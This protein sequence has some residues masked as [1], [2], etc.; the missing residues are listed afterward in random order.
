MNGSFTNNFEE[1]KSATYAASI[2]PIVHDCNQDDASQ[3]YSNLGLG[4]SQ[5]TVDVL[6]VKHA[7]EKNYGC[8]GITCADI[9]G[10][11]EGKYYGHYSQPCTFDQQQ[12]G[13][14]NTL[15]LV[16]VIVGFVLV[17]CFCCIVILCLRKRCRSRSSG[18]NGP[19][20]YEDSVEDTNMATVN[21]D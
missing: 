21:L 17:P 8:M 2:L 19:V 18:S 6:S 7:L 16:G 15:L 5:G 14:N 11:W 4:Q 13:G 1:V 3:I 20:F 9:G 10:V 12:S